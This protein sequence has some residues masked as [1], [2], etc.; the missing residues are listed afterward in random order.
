MF[1]DPGLLS[2]LQSHKTLIETNL[3]LPAGLLN[4]STTSVIQDT[5]AGSSSVILTFFAL[6]EADIAVAGEMTSAMSAMSAMSA[7]EASPTFAI[8]SDVPQHTTRN[9]GL[10]HEKRK[11]EG[12]FQMGIVHY[13]AKKKVGGLIPC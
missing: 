10:Y 12:K 5:R 13:M 9:I 8:T 2:I 1:R 3:T 6:C 11:D 7:T 4:V